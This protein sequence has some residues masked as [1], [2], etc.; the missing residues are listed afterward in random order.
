MNTKIFDCGHNNNDGKYVLD[1]DGKTY[2]YE[3][4]AE[5][6]LT[7]MRETGRATMYFV[8]KNSQYFVAIRTGFISWPVLRAKTSFHN[9]AG[10]RYDYWFRIHDGTLWHGYTVGDNTQIA[11]CKRVKE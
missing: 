6:E 11:H 8:E 9:L 2:C 4:N 1:N 10:V 3:C 5:K 7:N